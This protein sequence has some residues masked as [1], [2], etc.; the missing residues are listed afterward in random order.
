MSASGMKLKLK[1][2]RDNN[3]TLT[4]EDYEEM[5]RYLDGKVFQQRDKEM[6]S[7]VHCPECKFYFAPVC[8]F[9]PWLPMTSR[10]GYCH[11]GIKGEYEGET[12]PI[13]RSKQFE[14]FEKYM[15][16]PEEDK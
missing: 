14:N 4:A 12:P 11:H 1:L 13:T 9:H 16:K 7:L 5:S 3:F 10:Y 2:I 15:N 8:T 6:E